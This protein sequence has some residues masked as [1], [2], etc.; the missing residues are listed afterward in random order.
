MEAQPRSQ[1][2][3]SHRIWWL[4][5]Q[6][7]RLHAA[8]YT[9]IK[10]PFE[11]QRCFPRYIDHNDAVSQDLFFLHCFWESQYS[12]TTLLTASRVPIPRKL[13]AVLKESQ[14]QPALSTRCQQPHRAKQP[15][16]L[17]LGAH[18]WECKTQERFH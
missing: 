10:F 7:T 3:G 16:L 13:H 11:P 12:G 8:T 18:R 17:R 6:H 4:G 1:H 2:E 15:L 5:S 14:Q 9:K